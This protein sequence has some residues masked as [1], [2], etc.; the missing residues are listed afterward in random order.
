MAKNKEIQIGAAINKLLLRESRNV[1]KLTSKIQKLE[2]CFGDAIYP[3]ILYTTA[4]LEFE[5]RSA[6][7]HFREVL[8]HWEKMRRVIKRD[9]DFRVALLDYF[10]DVNKR[11]KNPKIIEIKIFQQTQQQTSVDEL[12]Q[13]YNYRYFMKSLNNE[14]KRAQRYHTPLSLVL[15]DVDEFKY[16]NDHNGHLTGNKALK[17]LARLIKQSVRDI[18]VAARYGGEEFALIL[19]GT[20]K[21]GGM[22]IADRIRVKVQRSRFTKGETQP[23]KNFTISGGLASLNE[24]AKSASGLIKKADQALYRAKAWGKNMVSPF[25]DEKRNHIRVS[26]PVTGRLA[27]ASH[28]GNILVVQDISEGGLLFHFGKSIAVDTLLHLSLRL[29]GQGNPLQCEVIVKRV[30]EIKK[31]KRYE[32]ATRIVQMHDQEKKR[33]K[34]FIQAERKKTKN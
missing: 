26:A 23:L 12:T 33:I 29:E 14:T 15:F 8:K 13:L 6:K 24:D 27:L 31:N 2:Q 22:V 25:V 18:D 5:K 4:H 10:I 11:I 28:V 20:N 17:K 21:E 30:K 9:I 3:L 32:V 7:K 34:R 16:Y 1:K 19:P